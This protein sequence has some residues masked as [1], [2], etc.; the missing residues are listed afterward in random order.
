M[1][2]W[3]GW[4]VLDPGSP[5]QGPPFHVYTHSPSPEPAGI[6]NGQGMALAS[7]GETKIRRTQGTEAGEGWRPGRDGEEDYSIFSLSPQYPP[8]EGHC[9]PPRVIYFSVQMKAQN[10]VRV[11]V[12][13]KERVKDRARRGHGS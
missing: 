13:E 6:N 2:K 3:R 11:G 10:E 12:L 7:G 5:S 9:K 8:L 4:R 1:A